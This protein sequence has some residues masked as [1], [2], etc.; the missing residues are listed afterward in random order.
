MAGDQRNSV[1]EQSI[2]VQREACARFAASRGWTADDRYVFA[3]DA[4]SGA[5]FDRPGLQALLAAAAMKPV[6]FQKLIV[7]E[8]SRIGRDTVKT[9]VVVQQLEDAGIEIW[10]AGDGR[11]ITLADES[12]EIMTL[13]G[14]WRDKA[15]RRKTITRVR[16]AAF[17][18][19]EKGYV[20]GGV[21]YGYRNERLPGAGKQPVR[22][23]VDEAQAAIVHRIFTETRDGRGL[24]RIASRLN[25][26]GVAGPRGQ[27]SATGVRE[28]LHRDLYQGVEIF[29]RVKRT[30]PKTR[31]AVPESEWKRREDESL[32]IVDGILW[33]A[34]HARK[35]QTAGSVLRRRGK[36][37]GKAESLRGK[38][39]LSGHVACGVCWSPM[40]ATQRGRNLVPSYVCSAHRT[41]GSAVCANT[42]AVPVDRL[43][44]GVIASL[45]DT[46]TT[47]ELRAVAEDAG[48]GRCGQGFTSRRAGEPA[49]LVPEAGCRG[50][51]AGQADRHG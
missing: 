17:N 28:I 24:I 44:H 4:V 16:R 51:E 37:M 23:V 21:V 6:P 38:Y 49:G 42:T 47:G 27:W 36:L 5:T 31:V 13:L 12:N 48:R 40:I 26:E 15:E 9:L 35:A 30:G 7:T 22:R 50:A 43:H 45:R 11:P 20:A 33:D 25:A 46:L 10:S 32:R 8:Q 1:V 19:H 18:Q 34:A 41:K 3:D 39:L 14:A 2:S 29:G